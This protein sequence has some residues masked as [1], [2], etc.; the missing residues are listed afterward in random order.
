M[1]E[2][3][4][5]NL[6]IQNTQQLFFSKETI[7]EL[8][9]IILHQLGLNNITRDAKQEIINVLIKNMKTIY[10]A[11]DISK[12]NNTNIK[13]VY[14]QFKE[15]TLKQSITEIKQNQTVEKTNPSE[16][17]FKRDF[18]SNPN[19]GNKF[20]DRPKP[21]KSMIA[22]DETKVLNSNLSSVNA[23]LLNNNI[24]DKNKYKNQQSNMDFNNELDQV[25][26]PMVEENNFYVPDKS[27][28]INME[29]IQKMRQYEVPSR[30][31]R[32]TTPDFLKP[33]KSNPNKAEQIN[34]NKYDETNIPSSGKPDFKNLS[35]NCFNQGFQGLANDIGGDLYSIDNIEK[36]LINT[37]LAED[38][39]SFEDRLKRLQ[40]DRSNLK[41]ITQNKVDFTSDN[42]NETYTKKQEQHI[43]N[44]TE[45]EPI[46]EN[47]KIHKNNIT[48]NDNIQL[49]DKIINSESSKII[50]IKKNI[51]DEFE[52]LKNKNEELENKL[53]L[54]NLKEISLSKKEFEV[55]QLINNYNY[56]FNSNLLQLEISDNENRSSYTWHMEK[57]PGVMGI[58]LI[59]YSLPLPK[60][61]IEENKN[62]ILN[63]IINDNDI[64]ISLDTGKYNID[65]LLESLNNKLKE[66]NILLSLNKQQKVTLQVQNET[67]K[68][69][70]IP[71]NL[72]KFNLGFSGIYENNT[73]YIADKIWDLRIDDRIYL[74][75]NNLSDEI[76]FG[77]LYFNG[78]ATSQFKFQQPFDLDKFEIIFKDVKGQNINFYGLPHYLSF[79]IEK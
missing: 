9:K 54:L 46:T 63:L 58:K 11:L 2:Q 50:E 72:S 23:S 69:L 45:V 36:P 40:S 37:E 73:L 41:P 16:L 35:S 74:Y 77:V 79:L 3:L 76:P 78:Q 44:K 18:N 60:F 62:N 67:D 34:N 47:K 15:Y 7:A 10:K 61:N 48:T 8:N 39:T 31:Q 13:S 19:P 68:V 53:N 6:F 42:F 59:S 4:K 20:L 17:K 65:D 49:K 28:S 71:T 30:N 43:P 27:N 64:K 21:S 1:V 66:Y 25:F 12:I 70:I 51:A 26:K 56:L 75:L 22:S 38:N 55:K 33:I 57:I 24:M 5:Q 52:L 14:D 29:N 32:P